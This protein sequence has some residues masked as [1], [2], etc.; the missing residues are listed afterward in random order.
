MP[1]CN[2]SSETQEIYKLEEDG[3]CS[4]SDIS[5]ISYVFL[6]IF[7]DEYD[8][9]PESDPPMQRV[10]RRQ[11]ATREPCWENMCSNKTD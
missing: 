4:V 5:C 10:G 1:F 11:N 3:T 2:F 9:H 6:P 8:F 7:S